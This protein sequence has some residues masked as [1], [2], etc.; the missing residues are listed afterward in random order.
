MCWY[1]TGL[2]GKVVELGFAT[3]E[4]GGGE[5][6]RLEVWFFCLV[7]WL[8]VC[9]KRNRGEKVGGGHREKEMEEMVAHGHGTEELWGFVL[10]LIGC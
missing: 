3:V 4:H 10:Y 8:F 7:H 9:R 2:S 1:G 6:G 5:D